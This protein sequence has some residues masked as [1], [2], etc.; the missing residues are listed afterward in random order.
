MGVTLRRRNTYLALCL[1][2]LLYSTLQF[3]DR[4]CLNCIKK[5]IQTFLICERPESVDLTLFA[6]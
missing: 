3:N 6:R 2:H 4:M 1:K 5:S